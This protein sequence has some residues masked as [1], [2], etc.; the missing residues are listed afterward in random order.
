MPLKDVADMALMAMRCHFIIAAA[1]V[2]IARTEDQVEEQ[3]QR[4]VEMRQH[5]AAFDNLLQTEASPQDQEVI[6]D[7]V[8]KL[9]MLFVFDFEAAI[10]LKSWDNLTKIVRQAR[11]C[12]DEVM[13]KAMG[14][15]LLRSQASGK[16]QCSL[17]PGLTR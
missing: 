14:D 5:I 4:Y 8:M 13:Y 6:K 3:L 9:S 16:G 11:V 7:L 15:C 17:L 10:C 12:K 1:L 2:S